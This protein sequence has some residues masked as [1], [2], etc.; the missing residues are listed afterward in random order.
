[1]K[2]GRTEGGRREEVKR[3]RRET[4]KRGRGRVGGEGV[5]VRVERSDFNAEKLDETGK[6]HVYHCLVFLVYFLSNHLPESTRIPTH[7]V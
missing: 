4:R 1:M 7:D 6:I 5:S 3:G 2:Q